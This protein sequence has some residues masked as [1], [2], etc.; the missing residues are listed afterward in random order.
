MNGKPGGSVPVPPKKTGTRK[1][2]K[3]GSKANGGPG[4][5]CSALG[6]KFHGGASFAGKGELLL[7]SLDP[8]SRRIL[9]FVRDDYSSLKGLLEEIPRTTLYRHLDR[10]LALGYVRRRGSEYRMTESGGRAIEES[11]GA[12][13]IGPQE[14]IGGGFGLLG[15]VPD[16]TLRACIR[17]M[18]G[19]VA[20]RWHRLAGD[21]HPNFVLFGPPNSWKTW[22]CR[23]VCRLLG[24][25]EDKHIVLVPSET[26]KSLF[27]RR[28]AA[29]NVAWRRNLLSS[30][31]FV[32]DEVHEADAATRKAL[33]PYLQGRLTIPMENDQL[34][35]RPV[36]ALT[37]NPFQGNDLPTLTG[38]ELFILRRSVVLD[39]GRVALPVAIRH[40]GREILQQI[41][42]GGLS[43]IPKPERRLPTWFD[44][45]ANA[46]EG[47]L[48]PQT[49][50]LNIVNYDLVGTLC[51]G[52]SA[53]LSFPEAALW[54][55]RDYLTV[56]ET[57]GWTRPVWRDR[58]SVIA[59]GVGGIDATTT[60]NRDPRPIREG[61]ERI[62]LDRDALYQ[63]WRKSCGLR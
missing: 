6:Q 9:E 15:G 59:R 48:S 50:D 35:L 10:L 42:L 61:P 37:L 21:T 23:V 18:L 17:L 43:S 40:R 55:L 1:S 39:A 49:K 54:A 7:P 47:M 57:L 51:L 19:A 20:A 46:L 58:L 56:V 53:Y 3:A 41:P 45:V 33:R 63:R 11:K 24:L 34:D 30:P 25:D 32:A 5:A 36:V 13:G 16:S 8:I 2:K 14:P 12:A 38:L 29:G 27:A 22:T 4:R 26:G 60:V 52:Y 31:F 62:V 28:D 44:E